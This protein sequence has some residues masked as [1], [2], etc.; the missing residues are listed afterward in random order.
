[1]RDYSMANGESSGEFN[2]SVKR[3]SKKKAPK[4]H[5]VYMHND[6]YTTMEFVVRV[7][8][9][10]FHKSTMEANSIMLNIHVKGAGKCGAYPLEIAE[11]KVNKVHAMA[12][13]E[14]FPLRC[15]IEEQ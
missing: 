1:M 12:R 5:M 15:T 9:S 8:E 6:N 10:V 11:T 2:A 13:K 14:E 3:N 4:L 7:L